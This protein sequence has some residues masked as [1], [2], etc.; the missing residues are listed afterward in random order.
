MVKCKNDQRWNSD[1]LLNH[2]S[3]HMNKNTIAASCMVCFL[4]AIGLTVG[5]Y[6]QTKE[7]SSPKRDTLVIPKLTFDAQG[8]LEI[9]PSSTS[10][11]HDFDFFVGKWR[12]RNRILKKKP[13]TADEWVEFESTQEMHLVLN[14]L[15][16]VDNFLAVR[17]GKPFE[18]MTVRLFNPETRLWS[19][20]WADS[21]F[22][23]LGLPPV[24]GSFKNKV[25][26][27]FSKSPYNGKDL[28][29]V[30]RWDA[31]DADHPVWSQ[32][33]SEDNGQTWKEWNWTMYM[34]KV[35]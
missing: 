34:T 16:N 11:K 17:D 13:N 35:K 15:G 5:C 14:G 1:L 8:E 3:K 28:I 21:N 12:L 18:G 23:V 32:T 29:T 31:R 4:L 2:K 19:I 9:T 24:V 7:T 33:F 6:A 30:Y 25:G 22:G 26:H 27:F 10:S 20:Y